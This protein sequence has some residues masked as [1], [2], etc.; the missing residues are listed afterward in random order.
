MRLGRLGGATQVALG[1]PPAVVVG[2]SLRRVRY[3]GEVEQISVDE[4]S[5]EEGDRHQQRVEVSLAVG[6]ECGASESGSDDGEQASGASG[7][8]G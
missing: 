8:Q 7:S 4:K 1:C 3:S 2:C 6:E 5:G